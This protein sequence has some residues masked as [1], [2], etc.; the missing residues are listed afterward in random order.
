M[1]EEI[2]GEVRGADTAARA[3]TAAVAKS[4]QAKAEEESREKALKTSMMR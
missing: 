3:L 1:R 2:G 4:P